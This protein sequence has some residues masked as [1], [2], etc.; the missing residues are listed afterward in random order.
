MRWEEG[1]DCL[2]WGEEEAWSGKRRLGQ[3]GRSGGVT[4]TA[5][6]HH[7]LPLAQQ[8]VYQVGESSCV[9]RGNHDGR[10]RQ[11]FSMHVTAHSVTP[12]CHFCERRVGGSTSVDINI[13]L[14]DSEYLCTHW[15]TSSQITVY[16]L[17]SNTYVNSV[18][19]VD[20]LVLSD[21]P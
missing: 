3:G 13:F 14:P 10:Y 15:N 17:P 18:E 19:L 9:D 16:Y 4:C 11:V 6:Q 7:W 12:K 21:T 5:C 20:E 1:R 8:G 2:G